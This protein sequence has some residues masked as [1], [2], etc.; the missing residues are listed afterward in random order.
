MDE[1]AHINSMSCGN[2][3]ECL[4]DIWGDKLRHFCDDERLRLWLG[5]LVDVGY[6]FPVIPRQGTLAYLVQGL[7]MVSALS[8]STRILIL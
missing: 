1:I 8:E 5:D 3:Q 6:H 4:F 7:I 2:V